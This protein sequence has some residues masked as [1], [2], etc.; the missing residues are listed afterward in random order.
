LGEEAKLRRI[1]LRKGRAGLLALVE[2]LS[3]SSLERLEKGL[4][5]LGLFL[6]PLAVYPGGGHPSYTTTKIT[7]ALIW[8]GMLLVL[9]AHHVRRREDI[10]RILAPLIAAG[11][12]AAGYALLQYYSLFTSKGGGASAMISTF[13]NKNYLG[14]YLA[15][16][17][18]PGVGIVIFAK[19]RWIKLA[20]IALLSLFF[21]ALVGISQDAAWISLA[22]SGAMA[23]LGLALWHLWRLMRQNRAWVLAIMGS[24]LVISLLLFV[25][26]AVLLVGEQRESRTGGASL[27][28]LFLEVKRPFVER[29]ARIRLFDWKIGLEMALDHP[30]VGIGLGNYK[31]AYLPYKARVLTEGWGEEF[32]AKHVPPAAQAHNDYLQWLAETGIFGLFTLLFAIG[33]LFWT[34]IYAILEDPEPKGKL[35]RLAVMA[36]IG[37]VGAHAFVSFPFH[38]P[39]SALVAVALVGIIYSPHLS[40]HKMD[41]WALVRSR[42]YGRFAAIGLLAFALALGTLGVREF[43]ANAHLARAM[44]LG[45]W[46]DLRGA[47]LELERSVALSFAPAHNALLLGTLYSFQG[48]DAESLRLFSIA[49]RARPSEMAYLQLGRALLL[50]GG[51]EEGQRVLKNLLAMAPR[52]E[53][54]VEA[55]RLWE[56]ADSPW[57]RELLM[58]ERFIQMGA[59]GQAERM[60]EQL[61]G[62]ELD[63]K[64]LLELSRLQAELARRQGEPIEALTLLQKVLEEDPEAEWAALMSAKIALEGGPGEAEAFLLRAR[65]ILKE[66]LRLAEAEFAATPPSLERQI[67]R[68]RLEVLR[69][70]EQE[71]QMLQ[72][73]LGLHRS[74]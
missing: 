36:G 70:A 19:E 43:Q 9:V 60:I 7:V 55:Y 67:L 11:A 44:A 59:Y 65:V 64:S 39:A 21:A 5:Q 24:F 26:V 37:T 18:L 62:S 73:Q 3:S 50:T 53:V 68:A 15:Y 40:E 25:A 29:S 42:W 28:E 33:H 8:I 27:E 63:P 31:L 61:R 16:L 6:L 58:I 10:L 38:L 17:L 72:E 51:R 69:R 4:L 20:I 56:R 71:V 2:E 52:S 66:K 47:Q 54:A 12:I 57:I 41:G 30:L 23:L 35:L 34:G 48:R 1:R 45:I 14:G 46:G 22:L 32:A 13:G 49:V 74:R